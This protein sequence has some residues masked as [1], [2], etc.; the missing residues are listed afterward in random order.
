MKTF[1]LDDQIQTSLTVSLEAISVLWFTPGPDGLSEQQIC[2][3]AEVT[4]PREGNSI[5]GS[6]PCSVV[7]CYVEELSYEERL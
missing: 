2:C 7:F 1:H 5:P 3:F 4:S 6:F